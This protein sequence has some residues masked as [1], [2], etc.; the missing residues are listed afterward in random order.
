MKPDGTP[1][2]V[3]ASALNQ[4]CETVVQGGQNGGGSYSYGS[5]ASATCRR[6]PYPMDEGA[7]RRALVADGCY[8]AGGA[9]LVASA[10]L[11]WIA[12]G[13]GSG[14]RG[15]ALVDAVSRSG[16]HVPALS[17][18]RLT[19]VWYFV[20]ALGAA[21]LDQLRDRRRAAVVRRRSVAIAALIGVIVAGGAFVHLAGE[22][23]LGWGPK[24]ALAGGLVMFARGMDRPKLGSVPLD[25]GRV[26][27]DLAGL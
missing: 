16:K 12:R 17:A 3:P 9:A 21:E 5:S 1:M 25:P 8:L 10:F 4:L 7:R 22:A 23:R 11:H 15:H 27:S 2:M 13:A 14:L 24:V 18:G 19:V 26:R 20:P 6:L